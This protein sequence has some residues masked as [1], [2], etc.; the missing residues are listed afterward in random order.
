[1]KSIIAFRKKHYI[2]KDIPPEWGTCSDMQQVWSTTIP[3]CVVDIA[4][5]RKVL[6]DK[7]LRLFAV[8]IARYMPLSPLCLKAVNVAERFA[9]G[10]ATR[11]ELTAARRSI[12]ASLRA[13]IRAATRT[14]C[15]LAYDDAAR[16]AA[17]NAYGLALGAQTAAAPSIA[18]VAAYALEGA[19]YAFIAAPGVPT[20]AG[21]AEW[22]RSNTTP[23]FN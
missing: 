23:N 7:E 20:I 5:C 1:M 11:T 6:T 21:C 2:C 15:N 17:S 10:E 16:E 9:N 12:R 4:L 18:C 22:L 14:L 8:F 3:G 13:S 19:N